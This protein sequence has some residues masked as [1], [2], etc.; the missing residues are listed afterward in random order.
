VRHRL[1]RE[2]RVR[3]AEHAVVLSVVVPYRGVPSLVSHEEEIFGQARR[4]SVHVAVADFGHAVVAIDD[5]VVVASVVIVGRRVA[6]V[7]VAK[8]EEGIAA[9]VA[10]GFR[11]LSVVI[12][13]LNR[14]V[15]SVD[16]NSLAPVFLAPVVARV[17]AASV[18]LPVLAEATHSFT[19]QTGV[20]RH[21]KGRDR[22]RFN[23][24]ERK[25]NVD[26]VV[27]VLLA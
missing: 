1:V 20:V 19:C 21:W 6:A 12:M 2:L 25:S 5:G 18:V 13:V 24:E 27:H 17:S 4:G 26:L 22:N 10:D 11:A 16:I 23:G 8:F 15:S 3:V 14:A 9:I 7:R